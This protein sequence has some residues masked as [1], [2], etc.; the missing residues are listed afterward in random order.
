MND[1]IIQR[2][3]SNTFSRSYLADNGLWVKFADNATVFTYKNAKT[4]KY[5][6]QTD[7]PAE[8]FEIV[9]NKKNI[10]IV[11]DILYIL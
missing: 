1:F 7:R 5:Y 4:L 6:L 3:D 9:I 2:F 11:V 10:S 8:L